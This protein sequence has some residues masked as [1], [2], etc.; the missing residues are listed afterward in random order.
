MSR[1]RTWI[2]FVS[3][4]RGCADE[5]H[6]LLP[7]A[8][9]DEKAAPQMER[10]IAFADRLRETGSDADWRDREVL[11]SAPKVSKTAGNKGNWD[12]PQDCR[13]AKEIFVELRDATERIQHEMR[14]EAI[15]RL[16]PHAERF[17]AERELERRREGS[18]DFD[19]LLN[20]ARDL[21]LK[22]PEARAYFRRRF[23][24]L[25]VDEFQD[26]DP[27]QAEIA[28]L[29]A[30]DEEP[31]PPAVL[32]LV[33]RPGGLT[34][35]ADPKQSIYR[36]RGADISVY[37]A[38]RNG[39]L[40]GDGPQLVQNFR[41]TAGVIDWVNDV[42]DRAFVASPGVQP[43]N[44]PLRPTGPGL[45]D[46]S[47]SICVLRAEP[48]DSADEARANEARLIAGAIRRAIDEGWP[49]RDETTQQERP[50]TF[51]DVAILFP[52]R[53]GQIEFEAALRG[54][55]IPYRVEGGRGFFARQEIL[56]LASLLTAID[57]PADSVSL[58]AVLRSSVF[59]C[60]DEEIYLHVVRH[61]RLDFRSDTEGSPES[62]VQAFALLLDLH[63]FRSRTSLARLV[64]EAVRR[65]RLVEVA[66]TGWDGKQAAA[67]V[68]KLV[69]QARAF[70]GGGGGGLRSFARWLVDQRGA[71]DTED[72]GVA[73]ATD[74]AVRLVTMHASKGLEFPIV[75]LANLGSKGGGRVQPVADRA[76]RR[77]ELR[78]TTNSNQF[79]TPG[80]EAAW[81]AE[82]AQ[83]E[84]E[85]LR[86]LYVA[87]TRAR[88]RLIIPVSYK[89]KM[90]TKLGALEPSLPGD[91]D[92]FE[93]AMDGRVLLDPASLA[94]P[95]EDE[96]P[97]PFAPAASE[98]QRALE[99]R[100]A[101]I[102]AAQDVRAS[103]RGELAIFPASR[104]EGDSPL[105][106]TMIAADDEPLIVSDG[107]PAPIGEAMH[108]VLEL[109][110]L[111][112]PEDVEQTVASVCSLAGLV[113]HEDQ[114]GAARSG[115]PRVACPRAPASLH[116]VVGGGAVHD[117][118]RGWVCDRAYRPGVRGGWRARRR[119]LEVGRV[120][121][122]GAWRPR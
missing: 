15:C 106:A 8:A 110:D 94:I 42:F 97:A 60:T 45:A 113:G 77:L 53:T 68:A 117:A 11:N 7:H 1:R 79:E 33:P 83:L 37:D 89:G 40:R 101:W 88:D 23:P 84:A 99:A 29:I 63:R 92:P 122:S 85:E 96:P 102:G 56:D 32:D 75:A 93:T 82:K 112:D 16:I 27:V 31:P 80:F 118:Q 61:R 44:T 49:V 13:R 70:S 22:S 9:R 58:V 72:A 116:S 114:L 38:V 67:N 14:T 120:A 25:L 66:L 18:A 109:I 2:G 54:Q 51:G 28:I 108:R 115:V 34:V 86:L 76:R 50:A 87:A 71:R 17:V 41:S 100:A 103:A 19:D 20:W 111:R 121:P 64:R 24:V 78:V 12:D 65:T 36:F 39:P 26:T 81:A 91:A 74:N 21:L 62:I 35:V 47:R 95:R 119:R 10:I 55:E 59:A 73:E 5:L 90:S 107:P 105:S 104:D 4:Y 69:E 57:D 6:E 3:L 43:P 46:Q 98:V 30:S 48:A 52:T